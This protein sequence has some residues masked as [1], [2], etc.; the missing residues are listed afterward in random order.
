MCGS[1]TAELKVA[2]Y[3]LYEKGTVELQITEYSVCGSGTSSPEYS[4]CGRFLVP[5][6]MTRRAGAQAP[7]SKPS[8]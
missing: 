7:R 8:W 4:A 6:A 1:R 2:A 5:Y 3:S